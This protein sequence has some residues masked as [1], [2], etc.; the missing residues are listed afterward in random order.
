MPELRSAAEAAS[1]GGALDALPF[2]LDLAESDSIRA[3]E[4]AIRARLGPVQLL[5]ANTG[6]PRAGTFT[7]MESP[8]WDAAYRDI[9]A[10]AIE[11]VRSVLPGMREQKYGRIVLL[12]STSVKAPIATLVLSNAFRVG[13]VAA[14]KTLSHEV[15][16]DGVTVNCIA[17]GRIATDR[18][19]ELYPGDADWKRAASEIPAGRIASPQEFAPLVAFLCSEGAGYITGQTI[20]VDGG[21]TALLL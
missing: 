1:A 3:L 10:S 19:R 17:T 11:L 2:H 21:L 20:A 4:P 6:G 12:A 9:F 18:L 14:M 8:D 16:R 5:V 15:A 13:L 7:E